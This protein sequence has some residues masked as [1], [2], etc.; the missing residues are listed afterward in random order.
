M[1][2]WKTW[3]LGGSPEEPPQESSGEEAAASPL[4]PSPTPPAA[5]GT[6]GDTPRSGAGPAGSEE[7]DQLK[8]G[9]EVLPVDLDRLAHV[10]SEDG[11]PLVRSEFSLTTSVDDSAVRV[12]REPADSPWMQIETHMGLPEG[13]EASLSSGD[14]S[15]FDLQQVANT[16]NSTHL[17]PTAFAARL[18]EQWRFFLVSRF[19]VGAGLSDRQIHLLVRRAIVVG[20]QARRDLP[21]LMPP[22]SQE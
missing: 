19:F 10:M 13:V 7:E 2:E 16:W 18:E 17:Q 9:T 20:L 3:S 15:A 1:S 4:P 21:G 12:H 5:P 11:F 6:P 22:S 8:W 14:T